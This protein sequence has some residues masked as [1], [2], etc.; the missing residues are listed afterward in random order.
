MTKAK[1]FVDMDGTLAEWKA[2]ASYEDLFVQGYFSTL[3][4]HNSVKKAV[5][6]LF[7]KGFEVYVLSAYFTES[8][9]ALQEKNQWVEKYL[10]YID[11]GHRLYVPHNISKPSYVNALVGNT[12]AGY[13]LLDDYSRNLHEW[14]A[15]GGTGIKLLNG[16]NGT[17][18]TW[19]GA[20]VSRFCC[21]DELADTILEVMQGYTTKG[22]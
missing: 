7:D 20:A 5:E 6:L 12:D 14:K 2:A 9:Y 1:L 8:K 10:P 4:P 19:L 22:E 15:A 13:I 11:A 17:K 3:L 18:G 16:V 21:A